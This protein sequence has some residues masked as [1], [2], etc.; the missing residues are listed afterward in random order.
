MM[1]QQ[2]RDKIRQIL[3]ETVVALCNNGVTFC[4][5]LS[6]EGLLGV[7][8]DQQEVFLI[9]IKEIIKTDPQ[10]GQYITGPKNESRKMPQLQEATVGVPAKLKVVGLD[11][12]SPPPLQRMVAPSSSEMPTS[13]ATMEEAVEPIVPIPELSRAQKR[14]SS[15]RSMI[16]GTETRKSGTRTSSASISLNAAGKVHIMCQKDQALAAVNTEITTDMVS[17]ESPPQIKEEKID[18]EYEL[19]VNIPTPVGYPIQNSMRIDGHTGILEIRPSDDA[20]EPLNSRDTSFEGREHPVAGDSEII[21]AL[22]ENTVDADELSEVKLQTIVT[23][24]HCSFT[25]F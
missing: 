24:N 21:R 19:A 16:F 15:S 14:K 11:M 23:Y 25:M 18:S 13:D 12:P 10:D 4:S 1:L 5:Q 22:Y 20:E 6:V 8:V 9:N 3:A 7:T 2:E 17:E